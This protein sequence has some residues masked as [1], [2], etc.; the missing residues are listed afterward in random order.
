[1][2]RSLLKNIKIFILYCKYSKLS[3]KDIFNKIYNEQ[4]WGYDKKLYSG[5]GSHDKELTKPY[6]KFV[7]DFL[8]KK[9]YTV[10]DLGCGDFNIGE[11]LYR[12]SKNY[13][14][15]DIVEKLIELN[16]SKYTDSNL[17]FI[18]MNVLEKKI[19]KSDCIIIRQVLQ[20]LDNKSIEII[21]KQIYNFK[22]LILTEH[23][24]GNKFIPNID[25][26]T[27]PTI[28]L[29]TSYSGV[30]LEK[31]PFDLKFKSKKELIIEDK[32]LGGIHKTIIYKL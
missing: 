29:D 9:N 13:I 17:H 19:P 24:P 6:L 3:V 14:A 16:K 22:F 28:R 27:G 20:H 25:K 5:P 15:I 10:T 2:F 30:N 21:L 26:F 7:Q 8:N 12:Y 31:K 32:N 1:M 23:L 4:T 11:K 18:C